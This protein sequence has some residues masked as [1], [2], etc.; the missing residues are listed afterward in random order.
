M[1]ES[2]KT[3]EEWCRIKFGSNISKATSTPAT[4]SKQHATLSKQHST[5]LPQTAT[6]SNDSIVKFRPFDSVECCF[7]IVESIFQ[8]VAFDN[9]ASTLLLVWTGLNRSWHIYVCFYVNGGGPMP[10]W[11]IRCDYEPSMNTV[12]WHKCALYYVWH[13]CRETKVSC[14]LIHG[15]QLY[16]QKLKFRFASARAHVRD[17]VT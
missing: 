1:Q 14:F 5:L 3:P 12:L 8:L 11:N 16:L 10:S 9:V 17:R 4:M 6:M 7:D 2:S 15:V 13:S